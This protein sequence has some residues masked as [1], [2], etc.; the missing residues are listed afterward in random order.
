VKKT[1]RS[2]YVTSL[3]IGAAASLAA[4]DRDDTRDADVKL[5]PSVEACRQDF[6]PES[7]DEGLKAAEAQHAQSAPK[8]ASRDECV[9]A[10]FDNC[11]PVPGAGGTGSFMPML[12][13][14]MMGR[15]LSQP[16]S[17]GTFQAGQ[18]DGGGARAPYSAKP[19]YADR[20]GYVYTGD[21]EVSRLSPAQD[22]KGNQPLSVRTRVTPT[23]EVAGTRSV[24][25]GGFG[26]TGSRFSGGS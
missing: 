7:C 26:T 18:R 6:E 12:M 4:C 16:G 2:G 19:V 23:G 11:G 13:G 5:Y 9:N 10:G 17:F 22:V 3:V 8:F 15:S 21:R 24:S 25:R 20:N 14:Y 1:R